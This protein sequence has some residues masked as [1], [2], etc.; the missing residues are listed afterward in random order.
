MKFIPGKWIELILQTDS[1]TRHDSS[2]FVMS[3]IIRQLEQ[4]SVY[5]VMVQARNR[6]GW[7]EV[8]KLFARN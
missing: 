1:V 3:Y 4:N 8:G 6:F 2:H 7:N 5:E